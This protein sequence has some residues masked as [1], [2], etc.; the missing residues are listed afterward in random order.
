VRPRRSRITPAGGTDRPRCSRTGRARGTQLE[1]RPALARLLSERQCRLAVGSWVC[2]AHR[3]HPDGHPHEPL[4]VER[5]ERHLF[6]AHR[7]PTPRVS[8]LWSWCGLM[9]SSSATATMS[10]RVN[11]H[12]VRPDRSVRVRTYFSQSCH[13]TIVFA[14]SIVRQGSD[15]HCRGRAGGSARLAVEYLRGARCGG[16]F[17]PTGQVLNSV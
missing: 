8:A 4:S 7:R 11:G 1:Y 3:G 5:V 13:V 6:C 12:Q 14:S 9:Q 17:G 16:T 10:A 2:D 15:P